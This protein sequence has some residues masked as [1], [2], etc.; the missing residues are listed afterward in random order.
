[1]H[2]VIITNSAATLF[3]LRKELVEWWVRDGNKVTAIG[4]LDEQLFLPKCKAAG[5]DYKKVHI[6]RIGLNPFSDFRTLRE[7]TAVLKELKPDKVFCT[8]AKGVAY[9]AWAARRAGISDVYALISGLGSSFRGKSIKE[10]F[11]G[12]VVS[13]LYKNAF[14][15][16]ERVIFQNNDDLHYLLSKKLLREEQAV[17]VNGSGVDLD[18][19]ASNVR[20]NNA[21]FLFV[22]RLLRDKGVNEYIKAAIIVKEK[23]PEASFMV[24]GD[25]DSNPSSL[26]KHEVDKIR[27]LG[28][29]D[30]YGY[31]PD[32]R[33][34]ISRADIFVLPS[35][36]EG[37]PRSVIE[38]MSMGRPILTTNA[39]GCR[40][41]VIDGINGF[42]VSVGDANGLA[43]KMLYL[44]EHGDEAQRMGIES[45]RMAEEKYDLYK[46]LAEYKRIMRL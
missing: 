3:G 21:A 27:E 42:K 15:G 22:G 4:E 8:F 23:H 33:P 10:R 2:I 11:A 1:M 9:G 7:L 13:V 36:H 38:A 5:F 12:L 44:L 28:I 24:V 25:V 31:Q 32:V 45:R 19:F 17:I 37:L 30:F 6:N 34:F 41:T 14:K 35:Y 16:C 29:V 40:E 26:T 46:I 18:Y 20:P 39:P 43:Q